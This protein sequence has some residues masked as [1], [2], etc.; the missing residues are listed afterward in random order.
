MS[1]DTTA[2]LAEALSLPDEE[3]E[4]FASALW[5]SLQMEESMTDS[6]DSDLLKETHRRRD[7]L[8]SGDVAGISHEEL[9]QSL[10]R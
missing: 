3:R 6:P 1:T 9:K 2:L 7:E 4:S 8:Q 5:D 10:G